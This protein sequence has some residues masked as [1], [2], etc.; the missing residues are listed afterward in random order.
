MS[1][2]S[3]F[4]QPSPQKSETASQ[5]R[6]P[7]RRCWRSPMCHMFS[8]SAKCWSW[9]P[10]GVEVEP[11]VYRMHATSGGSTA[12][13]AASITLSGTASPACMTESHDTP[14][15]SSRPSGAIRTTRRSFGSPPA[16]VISP[17]APV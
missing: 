16:A 2:N 7:A 11:E 6:S 5:R 14:P 9:T 15:G 12:S 1:A 13:S 3:A 10:F 17:S 8:M 4:S